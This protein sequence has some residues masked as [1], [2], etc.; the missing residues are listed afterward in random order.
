MKYILFSGFRKN[1]NKSSLGF[2]V[3]ASATAVAAASAHAQD[4][5]VSDLYGD[6][7]ISEYTLSGSPVAAP[8]VSGSDV[9]Q[10]F[11]MAI[12]GD[13]MYVANMGSDTIGT[14][15]A[16]TGA[17]INTSFVSGVG[18]NQPADILLSGDTLYVASIGG[19]SPSDADQG[20]I[21]AFDAATGA[22]IGTGPLATGLDY[23]EYMALSGNT[24]YVSNWTTVEAFNATT[25]AEIG[26]GPLIKGDNVRGL[27]LNG[28]DLY[29]V[30]AGLGTVTEYN[31]T[32]GKE[33]GKPLIK[34]LDDPRQ[35]QYFDGD[36]YVSDVGNNTITEYNATTGKEIG[37]TP[38]IGCANNPYNFIIAGGDPTDPPVP[39]PTTWAMLAAG[40]LFL[41]ARGRARSAQ[42]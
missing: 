22:M 37:C 35:I 30:D 41:Y 29:V 24:L 21:Y 33:I 7:G 10:P 40:V 11:G 17:P 4:I 34:G 31:A 19:S 28:N 12:S 25:G 18:L 39:E 6:S 42:I 9:N 32:T 5:Y 2:L 16:T 8:L 1:L 38:L 36:L 15:N 20:A 14:Y 13:T 3:F 23:S 27:A 26:T